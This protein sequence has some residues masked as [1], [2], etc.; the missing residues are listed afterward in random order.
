MAQRILRSVPPP[1]LVEPSGKR[2]QA[3][4]LAEGTAWMVG[5]TVALFFLPLLNGLI[6]GMVGGYK[7]GTVRRALTAAFLPAI[8][9]SVGLFLILALFKMPGIGALAGA[10]LG[11]VVLLADVGIFLGAAIGGHLARRKHQGWRPIRDV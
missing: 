11:L 1:V 6:G 8:V 2:Y 5:I 10:T 3:A 9:V 4:S 7:V